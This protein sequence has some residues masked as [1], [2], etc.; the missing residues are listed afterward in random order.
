MADADAALN[1]TASFRFAQAKVLWGPRQ[2][3]GHQYFD[4]FQA[5]LESPLF[6]LRVEVRGGAF[7]TNGFSIEEITAAPFAPPQG[8]RRSIGIIHKLQRQT[9]NNSTTIATATAGNGWTSTAGSYILCDFNHHNANSVSSVADNHGNNYQEL[10]AWPGSSNPFI[11]FTLRRDVGGTRG[12]GTIVTLTESGS[13]FALRNVIALEV[14]DVDGTTPEDVA[15]VRNTAVNNSSLTTGPTASTTQPNTLALAG[16]YSANG[17]RTI[18]AVSGWTQEE[19]IEERKA[20]RSQALT[21]EQT[22]SITQ[23]ISGGNDDLLG[24]I[25]VCLLYTSDAADE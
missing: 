6:R 8:T 12:A 14:A 18:N 15:V 16:F 4:R 10:D 13:G 3:D 23:T 22:V 9:V 19:K 21:S 7:V 11:G 20:L 25:A 1:H 17:T 24:W 5:D 2:P